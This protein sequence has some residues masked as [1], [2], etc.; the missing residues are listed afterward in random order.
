MVKNGGDTK[1]APLKQELNSATTITDLINP[2]PLWKTT[3]IW[4]NIITTL[5]AIWVHK[6]ETMFREIEVDTEIIS[7]INKDRISSWNDSDTHLVTQR[8]LNLSTHWVSGYPST[9]RF[10]TILVDASWVEDDKIK[11]GQS[12]AAVAYIAEEDD[13]NSSSRI[14]GSKRM[15]AESALQAECYAILYG[16]NEAAKVYKNVIVK[17]DCL[18]AIHALTDPE[19][20]PYRSNILPIIKDIRRV[21]SKLHS[22]ACIWVHRDKVCKAN[23]LAVLARKGTSL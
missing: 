22:C 19:G 14:Q 13:D 20:V 15:V 2:Q 11:P 10:I 17:S 6:N 12:G 3:V 16:I 7:Q 18:R 9:K 8:K 1:L 5:W 4:V 23:D 21:A